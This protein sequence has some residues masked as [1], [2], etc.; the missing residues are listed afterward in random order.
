MVEAS[1]VPPV[2]T[3]FQLQ[4]TGGTVLPDICPQVLLVKGYMIQS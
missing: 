1:P 2:L 3:P 4:R